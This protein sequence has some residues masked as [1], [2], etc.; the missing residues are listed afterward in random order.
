MGAPSDISAYCRTSETSPEPLSSCCTSSIS[1]RP[2]HLLSS[3]L[4]PAP[5][6][7]APFLFQSSLLC[8]S[9]HSLPIAIHFLF[10][11]L[12]SLL[13]P[14]SHLSPSVLGASRIFPWFRFSFPSSITLSSPLSHCSLQPLAR[15]LPFSFHHSVFFSFLGFLHIAFSQRVTLGISRR[16]KKKLA[17]RVCLFVCLV[18]HFVFACDWDGHRN[19]S[20][21]CPSQSVSVA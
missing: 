4:A 15:F 20:F 13:P 16:L 10:F 9:T 2:F 19:V 17:V 14:L 11:H 3:S 5:H 1:E 6:S 12:F 18:R 8:P 21:L 7:T